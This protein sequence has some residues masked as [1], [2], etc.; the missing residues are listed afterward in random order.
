M[1]VHQMSL[2]LNRNCF[3]SSWV[4][5]IYLCVTAPEKVY[6]YHSSPTAMFFFVKSALSSKQILQSII[7]F[8]YNISGFKPEK[9][10]GP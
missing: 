3:N 7:F 2:A 9:V 8:I 10:D 5:Y 1:W 6:E 4:R